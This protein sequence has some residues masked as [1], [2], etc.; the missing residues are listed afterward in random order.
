[1][2]VCCGSSL[3]AKW[4]L[5]LGHHRCNRNRAVQKRRRNFIATIFAKRD[6]DDICESETIEHGA[7]GIPNVEHQHAQ[8]A[9]DFVRARAA[10][11]RCLTNTPN[12]RQWPLNQP[13]DSAEFYSTHWPRKGVA[14]KLSASAFHV[15]G[16]L[17]LRKNL[18]KEFARQ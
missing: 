8:A 3:A 4:L 7:D 2:T 10:R 14:A 5:V 1:M 15:S 13:N 16:R 12:R 17:E 6:L 11:V 18:L 9:V